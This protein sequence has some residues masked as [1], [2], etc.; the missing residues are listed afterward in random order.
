MHPA[1]LEAAQTQPGQARLQ[2]VDLSLAQTTPRSVGQALVSEQAPLSPNILYRDLM[3]CQ[4]FD[5]M[6]RLHEISS[7]GLIICGEE[8]NATPVKYSRFLHEHL[9]AS[10]LSIIPHAGHYVL[11]E[12]PEAV[13]GAIKEWLRTH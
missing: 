3:A 5:C 12:Q 4:T 11:R 13:S 8:D 6:A 1:L 9:P 2:L 10:S 7:P